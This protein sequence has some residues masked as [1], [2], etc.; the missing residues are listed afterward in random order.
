MPPFPTLS[1]RIEAPTAQFTS[2]AQIT[3]NAAKFF[4]HRYLPLFAYDEAADGV[5]LP[6][7]ILDHEWE[8]VRAELKKAVERGAKHALIGNVGHLSLAAE[9]LALM[10]SGITVESEY[11]RG[12]RFSFSISLQEADD[13]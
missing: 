11:G 3:P 6:P 8:T 10:G 9:Y 2:A 1:G 4:A 13:D 7:V 5:T 12:S